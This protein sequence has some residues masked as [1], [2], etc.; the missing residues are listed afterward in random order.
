LARDRRFLRPL[1]KHVAAMEWIV[2]ENVLVEQ[3]SFE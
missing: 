1:L 2:R 3:G